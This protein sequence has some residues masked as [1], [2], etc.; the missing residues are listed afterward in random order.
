MR[1]F[2]KWFRQASPAGRDRPRHPR[3]TRLALEQLED[4]RLLSGSVLATPGALVYHR[5]DG[6]AP[7]GSTGP[8][9]YQ[10][11]QIRHAYGFDRIAFNGIPGDGT[12][13]TIA[14]AD[15]F[16]DPSIAY[17]LQQFDAA[18]GLPDP[19]SF[20][21]VAQDGSS[22]LP[23]ADGGWAV[24]I[25]LDVEWAHAIAPQANILLVEASDNSFTNLL[26]AVD[27][28]AAQPGVV[29]VSMSWGS[30]E[31]P[32]EP[33][34]DGHFTTPD[35]QAGVTFVAASG[36]TG[37]IEYPAASP[38]V[39]GVGGTTLTTDAAGNYVGETGWAG[40]GGG[41]SPYEPLPDY[42]SGFVGGSSRVSPDVAY[43]ADPATG[44]AV[45]DSFNNGTA[46]PWEQIG[47]TS[48]G[49]PQWAALVAL[50]DQGRALNG[51]APL[52]GPGQTLPLVYSLAGADCNDVSGLGYDTVTGLGSPVADQLVADLSQSFAGQPGGPH[53]HL[54][55][56][57][58]AGGHGH[59]GRVVPGDSSL[60]QYHRDNVALPWVQG[61]A[62]P[63]D[64][65]GPGRLI[66]SD[67]GT[68]G[69]NTSEVVVP[70]GGSRM[71]A[72][73]DAA[74][75]WFRGSIGTTQATGPASPIPSDFVTACSPLPNR[76]DLS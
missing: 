49:A 59:L 65:A 61:L 74:L 36:D 47:G 46:A 55:S 67:F 42:Q 10:P 7:L 20:S 19:P 52:D 23:A 63:A 18:F 57:S 34:L 73:R 26:T 2:L 41:V 71:H 3:A 38:N 28:A 44:F 5:G 31:F 14:I 66:R 32:S 25:A 35:G 76:E 62:T 6:T 56:D 75:R 50:A 70:E 53:A 37:T 40:S 4:R 69:W 51:L 21:K 12:G 64:A 1:Q 48:A 9:G 68:E 11:A 30:G 24:E 16:D 29:A 54:P 22:N 39:L 72:A 33:A 17:D 13:Q 43:D 8:V 27:Y 15:A 58:P 45:Y 60:V